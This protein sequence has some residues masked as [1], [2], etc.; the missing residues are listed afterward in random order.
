[1]VLAGSEEVC[2]AWGPGKWAGG[3]TS[4]EDPGEHRN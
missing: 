2:E 1:M 3:A 4:R